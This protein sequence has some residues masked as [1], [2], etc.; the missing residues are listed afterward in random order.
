MRTFAAI[1]AASL[2]LAGCGQD[3][4]EADQDA[5][6]A[7]PDDTGEDFVDAG[8]PPGPQGDD[9]V[10]GSDAVMQGQWFSRQMAG[11]PAALFGPPQSEAGFSVRC[12]GDDLVFTRSAL[13][14]GGGEVEMELMAG[15]R[16]RTIAA[17]AQVDPMPTVTGSLAASDSFAAVLAETTEPIAVA[18]AGGPSL[19]MPAHQYLRE[20]VGNC[21][22]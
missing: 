14:E 15:G 21:R 1:A 2:A 8:P 10:L 11:N 9:G 22:G 19:R 16:T 17:N 7:Q 6:D 20:V 13:V 5:I 4:T 18:V 3:G 12:A